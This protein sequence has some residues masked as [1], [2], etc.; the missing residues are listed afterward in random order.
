M[1]KLRDK[2]VF[3]I[4]LISIAALLFRICMF[5]YESGDYSMF[6]SKWCEHL[7][8]NGGFNGILTVDA[9]YNAVY[10]YFLAL[11]TY[12]PIK[13]LYSIKILS[14]IF[15]FIM[16]FAA[17]LLAEELM[18]N[19]EKKDKY[20]LA[21][22]ALVLFLPTVMINSSYWA[23]CD[24]IYVSFLLFSI[25]FLIKKKY[26]LTFILYGISLTFKLQ[27]IFFLPVFGI[28]YLK[29]REFSIFKFVWLLVA[30]FVLYIPAMIIGKPLSGIIDAYTTQVGKYSYKTVFGYPNIYNL[31]DIHAVYLNKPGIIFTMCLLMILMVIVLC[32]KGKIERDKVLELGIVTVLLVTYFLPEMHD[33]YGYAA[34]VISIIYLL[35]TRRNLI[36][37][38]LINVCALINYWMCLTGMFENYIWVISIVQFIP[39]FVFTKQFIKERI[40]GGI[41]L[42]K[43]VN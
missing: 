11:F 28:I 33:R 26:N 23:Q 22:Y 34:E 4:I 32:T 21:V 25:Y 40:D 6:L 31:Y 10:L 41:L 8:S 20:S 3:T 7:E 12:I 18:K 29:N 35:T 37:G 19:Y 9:D 14:I 5:N 1:M 30:N 16:A 42:K 24:S 36:S 15:D 39:V 2:K 38:I 27:A 13:Y 17:Y 43:A